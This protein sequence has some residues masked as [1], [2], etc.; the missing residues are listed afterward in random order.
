MQQINDQSMNFM[1]TER[2]LNARIAQLEK[3]LK[4]EKDL[5]MSD[6]IDWRIQLNELKEKYDNDM[7]QMDINYKRL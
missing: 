4:I 7:W 1:K 6:T 5:R 3:D 2:F